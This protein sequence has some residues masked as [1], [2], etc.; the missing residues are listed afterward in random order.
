MSPEELFHAAVAKPK[1]DRSD[2]LATACAG[3]EALRRRVEVLVDAHEN[4][5]SFLAGRSPVPTV[6][7]DEPPREGPGTLIGPYKL[8]EQIGEGGM[9]LVFVA[10]Q[11]LPVRRQVAV[12]LIKPGMDTREVVAR[13]EAE[14]QALA[15]FDHPH[16]AKVLDA[17]AS[18]Q[19][20]PFFVMELVR[21]IP[22]TDYCDR[23]GLGVR[24]RLRLFVQI[25]HAVQ[26][27]HHK[28]VIH[29]D[30]KPSNVLVTEHDGTPV[31]KV[32]DFGVAKAVGQRLTD[33]TVYTRFLRMVG[34]PLYMSPEQ[35]GLSEFDVDTRADI[36]SL[37]VILYELLTG[38]TPFD[39][40]RFRT[41]EYDE[42]R[43][44]IR[45]E[46]PP[47]PST[48][49]STL[50]QAATTVL[51]N[52]GTDPRQLSRLCR[53]ELDWI[54]MRALEKDRNRRYESA[55][56]F[57]ADV[58][59]YLRDEPV[60]AC[61]PSAGYRIR[62]FVRRN[63]GPVVAASF[64]VLALLG[65]VV[66][67]AIGM[68]R[69]NRER[70]TKDEV[71]RREQ[72][73]AYFRRVALAHREL[74]A[75]NVGRADQLLDECPENLRG[76]E[77]YYL[78][79]L[80]Y[81]GVPPLTGHD[82]QVTGVA[83]SP[84]GRRV[85]SGGNDQT[86]RIWDATSG[87]CRHKLIGHSDQVP[88]VAL[89]PD[90]RRIASGSAVTVPLLPASFT[91]LIAAAFVP[92]ARVGEIR[93]WDADIGTEIRCLRGGEGI[94]L[95]LA[96]SPDGR[97]LASAGADGVI[98]IW[99]ADT[100]QMNRGLRGH[101]KEATG[102]AFSPDG[103]R[104]AAGGADG[105]VRIWDVKTGAEL[106]TL[107]GHRDGTEGVAFSPDGRRLASAG[108]DSTVRVWDVLTGRE[109]FADPLVH[110]CPPMAVTFTPDGQRL[111]T[112]GWDST[113]KIW[114]AASG[115][116][117]LT[118]RG[119]TRPVSGLAFDAE[120]RRLFTSGE[121]GTIRIWDATPLGEKVPMELHTLG[122][123]DGVFAL[124]YSRD[125]EYL[126]AGGLDH[127][128]TI[129]HATS[130]QLARVL[131]GDAGM[132]WGV[133]F[134]PL[135]DRVAAANWDGQ[136]HLWT[137]T[138]GQRLEIRN[139]RGRRAWGVE[140]TGDGRL[141]SA[142]GDG[143]VSIWDSGG[144]E[145]FAFG[146]GFQG[147]VLALSPGGRHVACG[148]ADCV[149]TV[150]HAGTGQR[151]FQCE[152]HTDWVRGVAYSPDGH[153]IA[154]AS[155]DGTARIWDATT[156]RE[157]HVLKG[158][159]ERAWAV[160]FSPDSQKLASASL[161]AT[162]KVWSVKTGQ[163]IRT[164]RGSCGQVRAVAFSPDGKQ[165]AAGSGHYGKGEVRIWDVTALDDIPA[166]EPARGKR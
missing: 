13:F 73:V 46:E 161:D 21:G 140:Y 26:H 57:A 22:V 52:C 36:Y 40:D 16:I 31:A 128:V 104:L 109:V 123:T 5:G 11:E 91:G 144:R 24:D 96:F 19:G 18:S 122:H 103:R 143:T 116:E 10:E 156:G 164:L 94:V 20:R 32:I 121:D 55:A 35:A 85:V 12:K 78:R 152:G 95:G 88:C 1:P 29:R 43:R 137:T 125:G 34:S 92:P 127:R 42:V 49:L 87:Q 80:R 38:T 98:R 132:V 44:I 134:S 150:Y 45:E 53:G 100:G 23:A 90:A 105:T 17:G 129:W 101:S 110:P 27:A 9:G 76:W 142:N 63:Q 135:G 81:G 75:N 69:A 131:D 108:W 77:W 65:G 7:V 113:V 56:A 86:V 82:L 163:E 114:D 136:V 139:C 70:D 160:A 102:L 25:C 138:T 79:R 39:P 119:H 48:R 162:V 99:D 64:V 84:D 107:A 62:K 37:G 93:L 165:L 54:V 61:P 6:T 130:G 4:P 106:H 72:Q 153:F 111:A 155:F 14:R 151:I 41:A 149:V 157:I 33:K 58:E 112:A 68:V 159:A 126:A 133:A 60:Q 30:L 71:L 120:G 145:L 148:G 166:Q 89:S 83:V 118:L 2:F 51:V 15:L 3:D 146:G 115:E 158:H 8:L 59:R 147:C 66:G 124:A 47:R 117:I 67:T 154:S 97:S 141:A 28:G 74:E 50:G